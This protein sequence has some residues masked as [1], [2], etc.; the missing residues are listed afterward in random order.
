MKQAGWTEEM[1]DEA[2]FCGWNRDEV[3]KVRGY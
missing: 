3:S 2:L 1:V